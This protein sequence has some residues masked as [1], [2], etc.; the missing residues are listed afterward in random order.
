MP[1][2]VFIG[3][4]LPACEKEEGDRSIDTN[5][6]PVIIPA[7][8]AREVT[9]SYFPLDPGKVFTFT[10]QTAD[11]LETIVITILEDI[12]MVAGVNCTVVH[13]VVSL[14]G[15]MIEDTYDWYAQDLDGNVWYFGEDVSNY[16]NG[17]FKDKDGSFEA[18]IDGAKP[19]IVMLSNPVTEM[20]YRQEYY[21]NVAED[22]GKVVA[23][24]LTVTT[25][26]G[27]FTDCLKTADWNA[28]EPDAP[29]E[30]KYYAPG[31]GL[32]KEE[33]EGSGEVM[34]LI[35]ME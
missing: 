20:P 6:N 5:Y 19:G 10:A 28:L 18:G 25:P 1:V 34:E 17:V 33:T 31:V 8:F 32:V 35:S 26:Y 24:G 4:I 11:G 29:L 2:A 22:W 14:E 13:D 16:E 27:T 21:F 9:N 3:L 23:K 7:N 12:K 30:F 15:E